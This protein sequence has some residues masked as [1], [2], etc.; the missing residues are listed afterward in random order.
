MKFEN[1]KYTF[2]INKEEICIIS[3]KVYYK[4][5]ILKL[6]FSNF[7]IEWFCIQQVFSLNIKGWNIEEKELFGQDKILNLDEMQKFLHTLYYAIEYI[8]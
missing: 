6:F 3:M 5:K 4:H 2:F 7:S 8:C 1:W